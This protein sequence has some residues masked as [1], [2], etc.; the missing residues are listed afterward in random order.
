M[1]GIGRRD[2]Q[3]VADLDVGIALALHDRDVEA[4]SHLGVEV[5]V[6]HARLMVVP[7]PTLTLLLNLP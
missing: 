7:S 3:P 2:V 1:T 6:T 5:V 4:V